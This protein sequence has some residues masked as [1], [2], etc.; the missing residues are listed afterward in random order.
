MRLRRTVGLTVLTT[1]LAAGVCLGQTMKAGKYEV[2]AIGTAGHWT[3]FALRDGGGVLAEVKFATGGRWTA[4]ECAVSKDGLVFKSFDT[5]GTGGTPTL[6]ADSSVEV[7][8]PAGAD[9]PKV[10]YRMVVS[11]FDEKRWRAA[12]E[13]PAPLYF[14]CLSI[15]EP[16]EWFQGGFGQTTPRVDPYPLN[17]KAPNGLGGHWAPG[18][19]Y[20]PPLGAF[21]TPMVGLWNPYERQGL[22]VGYD[23]TEARRAP[24]SAKLRGVGVSGGGVGRGG[25]C[26]ERS[27]GAFRPDLLD[28]PRA[29]RRAAGEASA[30]DVRAV[31]EP[32]ARGAEHE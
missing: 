7:T 18:W 12:F 4:R 1:L 13:Q 27:E 17:P 29:G 31:C 26:P 24:L 11:G 19:S 14:L 20:A 30:A 25:A 5:A 10:A 9:F 22:F 2:A 32:P 16:L 3:G 15:R 21:D 6:G 8:F 23:F 28:G